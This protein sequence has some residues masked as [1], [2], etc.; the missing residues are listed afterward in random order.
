MAPDGRAQMFEWGIVTCAFCNVQV[1]RKRALR[2][3]DRK[4]VVICETCYVQW[5]GAGRKCATCQTLVR[6]SQEVGV[7]LD[8]HAFGHAN[9]GAVRL[10][11]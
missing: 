2:G 3:S 4:D 10:T 5:S 7:F 1:P 8:R 6:D 9:C 11:G